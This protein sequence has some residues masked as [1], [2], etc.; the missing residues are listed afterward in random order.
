M[1]LAIEKKLLDAGYKMLGNDETIEHLIQDILKRELFN[2]ILSITARIFSEL[3]IKKNIPLQVK[4]ES[5]KKNQYTHKFIPQYQE[6]KDEF[7]LQL[8]NEQKPSLLI[9]TKRNDEERNLQYALSKLFTK[10]EKYIIKRLQEEKSISKTDYEYY[11]RKTKKKLRSIITLEDFAKNIF[12]KTPRYDEE[13]FTLK[14]ML[15]Q[16]LSKEWRIQ[17]SVE[18]FNLSETGVMLGIRDTSGEASAKIF[19]LKQIKDEQLLSF[20]QKYKAHDFK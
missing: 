13:L 4:E 3:N 17:G 9:D 2:T 6:F 8:R 12:Q 5:A 10:K 1:G 15:E 20:L 14:K 18:E 11:S 7:E 19:T 16:W